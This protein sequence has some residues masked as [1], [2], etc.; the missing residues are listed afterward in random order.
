M[1]TSLENPRI[2]IWLLY[3][4][5]DIC[6]SGDLCCQIV[7][8]KFHLCK[9]VL[10]MD[11]CINWNLRNTLFISLDSASALFFPRAHVT[12]CTLIIWSKSKVKWFEP[13]TSS[14]CSHE[15]SD[16]SLKLQQKPQHI[17]RKLWNI[18]I[19]QETQDY[20]K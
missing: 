17:G 19:M 18:E 16:H 15:D 3:Y 13:L 4:L 11:S 12:H 7:N 8:S 2:I 1:Y 9:T 5:F 6:P 20:I 14:E 10:I